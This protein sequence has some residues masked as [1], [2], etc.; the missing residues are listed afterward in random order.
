M[1]TITAAAG[2][3]SWSVGSTWVG[4]VAPGAGDVARLAS[5]SGNV[6]VDGTSGSPN[7]CSDLDCTGYTGT[8][9]HVANTY[10]RTA[11]SI[12]LSST[13]T[14]TRGN[15]GTSTIELNGT[16]THTIDPAGKALARVS[17]I[18]TGAYTFAA[19]ASTG[20]INS[21]AAGSITFN[22]NLAYNGQSSWT[23]GTFD[24]NGYNITSG[25]QLNC[26]GA[27]FLF[28]DATL[29]NVPIT[30]TAGT[31]TVTGNV[32]CNRVLIS[33]SGVK[34]LNMGSGTWTL[35]N[36]LNATWDVNAATTNLTVNAQTSTINPTNTGT[37]SKT[38]R[39]GGQTYYNVKIEGAASAGIYI[40]QD[41]NTFNDI[42]LEPLAN[43][44]F[45]NGTT[46][47]LL[48]A[49]TSW[50][51]TS[52][53]LV[54]IASSSAS[55][56]ATVSL[57]AGQMSADYLDL[58]RITAAGNVPF[59]AG[60]NSTDGGNNTNWVFTAPPAGFNPAWAQ[61]SNVMMGQGR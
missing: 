49:P 6:T 13:M 39:G 53:N 8:L 4:G 19:G 50:L 52:G 58:T 20:P 37:S 5:T 59:Y 32:S 1:A 44:Q 40:F 47:T 45:T 16:G 25:S 2:G 18:N 55:V 36:T 9:N 41:S 60:A 51:G 42:I 33:G 22:G 38:F 48:T 17:L 54:T 29:G 46:S 28:N 11:G 7:L 23:A 34:T 57:S 61:G 56:N 31:I 43:V 12:T 14:Y 26:Q 10:I 3:G 24:M 30:F 35:S 21:T 27:T 15:V